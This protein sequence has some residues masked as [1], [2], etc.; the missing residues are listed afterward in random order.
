MSHSILVVLIALIS[1]S[2]VINE[3]FAYECNPAEPEVDVL[4][5]DVIFSGTVID[6]AEDSTKASFMV[7]TVWKG[8]TGLA[9][10]LLTS[11]DG[12][13]PYPFSV[14]EKYLVRAHYYWKNSSLLFTNICGVELFSN[15]QDY[16]TKLAKPVQV[17]LPASTPFQQIE[18]GI[19]PEYVT[20]REDFT[21]IFKSSNN[22][23]ACVKSKT[24]EKLFERGWTSNSS[25]DRKVWVEL[26]PILC[27]GYGCITE[28]LD[29]YNLEKYRG[30]NAILGPYFDESVDI[31]KRHY[32]K[33]GIEVFDIKYENVGDRLLVGEF[34]Y[35]R[36]N[37]ALF[38]LVS[39]SDLIKLLEEGFVIPS[40]N[41][42]RSGNLYPE[43]WTFVDSDYSAYCL[44]NDCYDYSDENCSG[45]LQKEN[46]EIVLQ[47]EEFQYLIH[48]YATIDFS[49]CPKN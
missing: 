2:F 29:S 41:R 22:S 15:S 32:D 34:G 9:V 25:E 11:E 31:I 47:D 49:T 14:E 5:F 23:P 42:M 40:E 8:K 19:L 27:H 10:T 21:L 30:Q 3:S 17:I 12:T 46:G 38:L 35:A 24:V 6:T 33:L 1:C 45:F 48:K 18:H 7:D 37:Y 39:S 16:I 36:D 4:V 28:W 20:C 26:F 43:I 44:E 13:F